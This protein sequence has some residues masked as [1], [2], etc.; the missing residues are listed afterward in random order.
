[1]NTHK[2]L[3]NAIK[4]NMN[5]LLDFKYNRVECTVNKT[6]CEMCCPLAYTAC[7]QVRRLE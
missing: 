3:E 6:D 1:M 5:K 2:Y 7:V 4:M